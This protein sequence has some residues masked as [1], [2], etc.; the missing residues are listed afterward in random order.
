M[1][2]N[3]IYKKGLQR[4]KYLVGGMDEGSVSQRALDMYARG[5]IG[6]LPLGSTSTIVE[7]ESD[8]NLQVQRE[9][10]LLEEQQN[11]LNV[12]QQVE[13]DLTQQDIQNQALTEQTILEDDAMRRQAAAGTE[14]AVTK[15]VELGS[16]LLYPELTETAKASRATAWGD[17]GA[18][19]RQGFQAMKPQTMSVPAGITPT[20]N[21]VTSSGL[22]TIPGAT[23]MANVAV[24]GT[25]F[26][27]GLSQIG[28]SLGKFAKTGAGIGTIASLAG[29]GIGAL[30]DDRDPTKTN[31]GEY[32]GSIIGAAGTGASLGSFLGPAGTVIGAGLG[33]LYGWLNKRRLTKKAREQEQ[34]LENIA[35]GGR[36]KAIA[37]H[38]ELLAK[39]YGSQVANIAA[40]NIKQK[41]ISG[42]DLGYNLVARHGGFAMPRYGSYTI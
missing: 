31:F 4:K 28:S 27:A 18:G 7:Q 11:L 36:N 13:R 19:I 9:Q 41:S 38:N 25:G 21:V 1:A 39:N 24:P 26:K 34:D 23:P 32:A 6:S 15:G 35:E 17:L 33:G 16:E 20:T 10:A 5:E 2:R 40:G 42:Q 29:M 3:N 37:D 22:H 30:S 12:Q 8:P 14:Q